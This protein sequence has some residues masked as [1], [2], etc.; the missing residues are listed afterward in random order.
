MKRISLLSFL[1]IIC[2]LFSAC[3]APKNPQVQHGSPPKHTID[4]IDDFHSVLNAPNLSDKELDALLAKKSIKLAGFDSREEMNALASRL[5]PIAFP[6]VNDSSILQNFQ[7]EAYYEDLRYDFVYFIG[8]IMYRF[9]CRP[10][11]SKN[12]YSKLKPACYVVID[13]ESLPMYSF[14]DRLGGELYIN[15]YQII[16]TVRGYSDIDQIS[17]EY[18]TLHYPDGGETST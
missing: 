18:F 9:Q 6:M 5:L 16:I 4:S 2:L 12:D 10:Y 17:F 1:L 11:E 3:N 13:G 8:G 14:N 7:F 15:D